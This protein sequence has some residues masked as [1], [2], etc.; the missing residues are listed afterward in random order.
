[1]ADPIV[2]FHVGCHITLRLIAVFGKGDFI[3]YLNRLSEKQ[4]WSQYNLSWTVNFALDTSAINTFTN[5]PRGS[6]KV[7]IRVLV[8]AGNLWPEKNDF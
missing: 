2:P 1:M 6:F 7:L 4:E 3:G 8:L 5:R